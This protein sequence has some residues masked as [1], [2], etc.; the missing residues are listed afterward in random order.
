MLE[1][2]LFAFLWVAFV[3]SGACVAVTATEVWSGP[4]PSYTR[5]SISAALF[6]GVTVVMLG[7]AP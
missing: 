4:S 5:F 3:A 2:L 6:I 7:V 1:A